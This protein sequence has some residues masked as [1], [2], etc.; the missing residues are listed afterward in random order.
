MAEKLQSLLTK[1][2]RKVSLT[3]KEKSEAKHAFLSFMNEHPAENGGEVSTWLQ[4]F[5]RPLFHSRLMH[6]PLP[7]IA[8]IALVTITGGSVSFMANNALPGDT[9]YP[10]KVSINEELIGLMHTTP[11]S[12]ARYEARRLS[13]RLNEVSRLTS[14]DRVN[15]DVWHEM[16]LSLEAHV[17]S[18][19]EYINTQEQPI[20]T[21]AT[22]SVATSTELRSATGSESTGAATDTPMILRATS[23]LHAV[24]TSST[25]SQETLQTHED[26]SK[27]L[28]EIQEQL[29]ASS[30]V[31]GAEHDKLEDQFTEAT[32]LFREGLRQLEAQRYTKALDSFTEAQRIVSE[33]DDALRQEAR[34]QTSAR[35]TRSSQ[36]AETLEATSTGAESAASSSSDTPSS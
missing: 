33:I 11:H 21:V 1:L 31:Q 4:Q 25:S 26:T 19:K 17:T 32:R 29:S 5:L 30:S 16:S 34:D 35:S 27:Q 24:G 23:S 14:G 9:L 6:S 36:I 15:S 18:I 8:G 10:I 22:T 3:A 13:E 20:D 2:T 7:Y 28:L 12:K